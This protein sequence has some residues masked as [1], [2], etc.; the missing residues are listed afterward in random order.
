[1]RIGPLD[2]RLTLQS[3]Q[4]ALDASGQPIET[5]STVAEIWGQIVPQRGAERFAAQQIVGHAVTTFRIRW[6]AGVSV[7]NRLLYDSKIWDILDVREV[8]RREALEIDG[9]AR[10]ES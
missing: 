4:T 1:M 6:R 8:R 3:K 10:S 9:S 5:W 7:L 2:R